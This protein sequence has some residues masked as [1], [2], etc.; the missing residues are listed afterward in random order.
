MALVAANIRIGGDASKNLARSCGATQDQQCPTDAS[1]FAPN[2]PA[3][4]I[5][6]NHL[7]THDVWISDWDITET[8]ATI[9]IYVDLEHSA[10]INLVT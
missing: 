2:Y 8:A 3:S 1:S 9:Y 5:N 6:N 4:K 10:D 7:D